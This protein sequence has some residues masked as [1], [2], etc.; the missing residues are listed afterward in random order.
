MLAD[1]VETLELDKSAVIPP[2]VSLGFLPLVTTL[3]DNPLLY[4]VPSIKYCELWHKDRVLSC[5]WSLMGK[6]LASKL[7]YFLSHLTAF[8]IPAKITS[9]NQLIQKAR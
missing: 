4:F 7:L 2:S 1:C 3:S 8:G 5:L 6:I 9:P